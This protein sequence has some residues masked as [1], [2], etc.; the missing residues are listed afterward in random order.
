ML[1]KDLFGEFVVTCD[2][3]GDEEFL[4]T[5]SFHNAVEMLKQQGFRSIKIGDNWEHRCP[6][7]K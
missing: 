7:C 5:E 3:C 4:D 6:C 2:K 1:E